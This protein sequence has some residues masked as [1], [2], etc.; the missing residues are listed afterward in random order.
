MDASREFLLE[1]WVTNSQPCLLGEQGNQDAADVAL[2]LLVMYDHGLL[3]VTVDDDG[4]PVFSAIDCSN[5]DHAALDLTME[6][7][8]AIASACFQELAAKPFGEAFSHAL[9]GTLAL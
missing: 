4:E 3:E 5:F 2:A 1:T 6:E 9:E 7:T 8:E